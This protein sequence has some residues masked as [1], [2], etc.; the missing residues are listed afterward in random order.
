MD[1]MV[2][3]NGEL[4]DLNNSIID[5][6]KAYSMKVRTEESKI[7]TNS[8]NNISVDIDINDQKLEEVVSFKYLGTY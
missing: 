6:A 2:C 5:R 7:M 8:M 3:S 4:Q 1:L